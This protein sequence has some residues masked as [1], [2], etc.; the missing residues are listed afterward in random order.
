VQSIVVTVQTSRAHPDPHTE[1]V[2][3]ELSSTIFLPNPP[4]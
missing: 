3:S 4:G 1:S 2:T